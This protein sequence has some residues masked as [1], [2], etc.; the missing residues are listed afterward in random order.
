MLVI[1]RDVHDRKL[2][3]QVERFN[4][5]L[6]HHRQLRRQLHLIKQGLFYLR[7]R[8]HQPPFITGMIAPAVEQRIRLAN[9]ARSDRGAERHVAQAGGAKLI[10]QRPVGLGAIGIGRR[11]LRNGWWC[12]YQ[13][14]YG[15]TN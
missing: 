9:P 13:A 14:R 5:A 3:A 8:V 12:A 4:P 6:P 1:F 11:H 7:D 15:H 10:E 2:L